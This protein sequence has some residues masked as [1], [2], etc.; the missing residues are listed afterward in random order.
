MLKNSRGFFA[1]GHKYGS[2]DFI[3]KSTIPKTKI[4]KKYT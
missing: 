3:T 4:F 1:L 2:R